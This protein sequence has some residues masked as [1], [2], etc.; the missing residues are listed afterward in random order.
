MHTHW[1]TYD[2]VHVQVQVVKL[3]SVGIRVGHK[4]RN[5]DFIAVFTGDF[6]GFRLYDGK[7]CKHVVNKKTATAE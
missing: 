3:F 2:T 7:D 6:R 5:R 1:S 4:D